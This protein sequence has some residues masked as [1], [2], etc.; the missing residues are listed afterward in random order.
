MLIGPVG[1]SA[2]L[3]AESHVSKKGDAYRPVHYMR[4]ENY[5]VFRGVLSI[6]SEGGL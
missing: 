6:S 5:A 2:V 3:R 4:T 1:W